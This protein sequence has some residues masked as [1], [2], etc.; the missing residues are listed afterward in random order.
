MGSPA[1]RG[2]FV[3]CLAIALAGVHA[4]IT[5]RAQTDD[6]LTLQ[7]TLG[8]PGGGTAPGQFVFPFGLAVDSTGRILVTDSEE[9]VD[10]TG[11]V[12]RAGDR[13]QVFRPDGTWES[14]IGGP[15]SAPGRFQYPTS[16]AVDALDK[17]VVTDNDNYR[18][19]VLG[20]AAS[21]GAPL[22]V[23][24]TYGNYDPLDPA[25]NAGPAPLDEFN[26]PS[27]VA[28]KPG[29]RLLDSTDT[30][31]RL[32]IV[33]NGNH[34]V[35]VLDSQLTPVFAF[36]GHTSDDNPPGTFEYPWGITIDAQGRYFVSDPQN[37][38]VQV[39]D[40]GGGL[41]WTF[42]NDETSPVPSA[43]DLSSPS[44]LAF[45]LQGRLLVADTDR[46]RVL[47]ID[48]GHDIGGASPLPRCMDVGTSAAVGGCQIL[49]SLGARYEA[50]PLGN[51]GSGD[52]EFLFAQ[53]VGADAQGRVM[54]VDTD[55]HLVKMFQPAQIAFTRVAATA[56]VSGGRVDDP[57]TL[58]ATVANTGG[59]ALMVTLDVSASLSGTLAGGLSAPVAPGDEHT[60]T[61]TY[62]PNTNGDLVFTVGANGLHPTG[63]RVP[64]TPV[65][66][67]P[68]IAIAPAGAAKLLL[69]A[70]VDRS[71]AGIGDTITLT[72]TLTNSG[73][74]AFDAIDP[75]VTFAPGTV[76]PVAPSLDLS[77]LEPATTRRLVYRYQAAQES[78]VAFAAA[79]NATYTAGGASQAYP[80]Q[81]ATSRQVRILTDT[82]PPVTTAVESAPAEVTGW[83]R[84]PFTV[85][86]NA[87][88]HGGSGVK[89]IKYTLIGIVD[90]TK[91]VE[92][93]SVSISI[94][95]SFQGTTTITFAAT[96]VN[97][98]TETTQTR[99]YLL[100]SVAPGMGRVDVA[101]PANAA[102]WHS[103][104][105]VVAFNAGDATSGVASITPPTTVT[106]EGAGQGIRGTARDAAGNE[107]H[108]ETLVNID[109]T[110]PALTYTLS[111][112]PNAN[113]WYNAPVVVSFAG[114]DQLSGVASV[115][116]PVTVSS[117]GVTTV[118]GTAADNAGNVSTIDVVVRMD[119]TPPIVT[120]GTVSGGIVWPPNH[121]MVPWTTSVQVADAASGSAGFVLAS[122]TSSEADDARGDGR[123]TN[124]IQ[125]F[126]I[127]T[128]DTSGFIRAERS[129]NGSGRA[130]SLFYEGRDLA[131]NVTSCAVVTGF[132]PHDKGDDDKDEDLAPKGKP[133]K[134]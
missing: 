65:S 31:G 39:F 88:D 112:P 106:T 103:T 130:Y 128:P 45:D 50:L 56:G 83:H 12:S 98:N 75:A 23:F 77:P 46:S 115:T 71:T 34:R 66:T 19:Q 102:G 113:G 93:S 124:D 117:D 63:V 120:C 47:R 105:V 73:D 80:T 3:L 60:F 127:G 92:G 41:L 35:V 99:H 74:T 32:A 1:R 51:W 119:R 36:G 122:A 61:F 11:V 111:R 20:S 25:S 110:P 96:D 81:T 123:T 15:G 131:G 104:S 22:R 84:A 8:V 48:I 129:G 38:R 6:V 121:A 55:G 107:S 16:V 14:M 13:I 53:G 100:D 133:G 91:T 10:G 109:K 24:G 82:T 26:W 118:R 17:I 4:S 87:D 29:T 40:A 86:L 18:I 126:A 95:Q 49:T 59:S 125:G 79:V 64:A 2:Y 21:G 72:L 78:V 57:V 54:V 101:P 70:S 30:Q 42:G 108:A 33:D 52:T 27:G 5:T 62:T 85:T 7:L 114:T 116:A 58:E 9:Y 43:G 94:P 132:V 89:S 134:T 97:G 90:E 44:A 68:A 69:A 67:S 76:T 37:H 28:V